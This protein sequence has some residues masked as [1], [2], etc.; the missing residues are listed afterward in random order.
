MSAAF[1]QDSTESKKQVPT[2]SNGYDPSTFLHES[3][4][5]I[6]KELQTLLDQATITFKENQ[7]NK[8]WYGR[9]IFLSWYCSLGDC[10]F[11]FR[12]TQKHQIKHAKNSR[13]SMGSVLLEA[14]FC[15]IFNWRIEFLTGGYGMMPDTE[16]VEFVKTV[17][18]VYGEKIWLNIGV[19]PKKRRDK[20]QPY[21]KGICASM[22][23]LHPELHKKVCPSKPIAPYD[24]MFQEITDNNEAFKKS[25]AVIV[26]MGDQINDMHYLFNFIEKHNLDRIT[27]YALKPIKGGM[28]QT[29]PT[30]E[31][32]IEWLARIRIKFPNLEIIAGTNLRR[33]EEVKYLIQA[34][35]NAIT[36]FPATKQFATKKAELLTSQIKDE[37]R[38]FI[39][40]LTTLKDINFEE[41][42][43]KLTITKEYKEQMI[44]KLPN[45]LKTFLNPKDKDPKY[46]E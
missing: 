27:L 33:S 42:I 16:L 5:T 9:C 43:S 13:R 23:T 2:N 3:D 24:N 21:V 36:K 28:F 45:Y 37:K 20:L 25:I 12:S 44:E 7:T 38:D 4:I 14:P 34:G 8:T 6:T 30:P 26:G 10:T 15:K 41:E 46:Q 31:L 1:N 19:I 39:S 17:S 35:A 32:Y 40:N 11:C 22:E 18:E 29:A